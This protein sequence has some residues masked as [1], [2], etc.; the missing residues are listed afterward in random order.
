MW[1]R[2]SERDGNWPWIS[3]PDG[4]DS[5]RRLHGLRKTDSRNEVCVDPNYCNTNYIIPAV[6]FKVAVLFD[7]S[8]TF[9]FSAGF[10][11]LKNFSRLTGIT[12]EQ[13]QNGD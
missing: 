1:L 13:F 11:F 10:Q 12:V 9:F 7:F 6:L 4:L 5:R 8:K 2:E 3:A